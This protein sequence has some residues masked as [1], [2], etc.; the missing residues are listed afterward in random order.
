MV[1]AGETLVPETDDGLEP[2][3]PLVRV[4]V[5]ADVIFASAMTIMVLGIDL[6]AATDGGADLADLRAYLVQ[7]YPQLLTYF[8]TFV[9]EPLVVA[10]AVPMAWIW[11][12]LYDIVLL[13]I[14]VAFIIQQRVHRRRMRAR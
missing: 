4:Q 1:A 7:Q 13:L 5:L 12:P 2:G 9:T 10:I 3:I 11:T 6:P 14:P 8:A